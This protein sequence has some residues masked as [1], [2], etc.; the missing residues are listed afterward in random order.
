MVPGLT[1]N[2]EY[3]SGLEDGLY[4]PTATS[5][6]F[7][8][9]DAAGIQRQGNCDYG[10]AAIT[11]DEAGRLHRYLAHIGEGVDPT[12]ENE[13]QCLSNATFD[14]TGLTEGGGL[15]TDIIAPNLALI[16]ASSLT[17][18]DFDLVAAR[19]AMVVWSPRSNVFLY[20]KTLN[21]TYLLEAGITVALGT[22]WLPSGSA[23]MGREAVCGRD[24]TKKS[25]EFDLNSQTIWEMMTINAAKVA[26]FENQLGSL[27]VGK[28]A[29]IVVFSGGEGDAYSRVVYAPSE[30]LELVMRGGK[31]LVAG[32]GLE[33]LAIA[34]CEGAI[35]G[36]V[37]K[38]ICVSD[39]VNTTFAEFEA[40]LGGVYPAILPG[41][42]EME[43]T[44][45]PTR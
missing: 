17:D 34:G 28:L 31:V 33:D 6:V 8:L 1:R 26:G 15:S 19:G 4:A 22:D 38:T 3:A 40:K 21:V 36:T 13:F 18:A 20:G 16:H 12:A 11:R 32:E 2:L 44:C 43:P 27:E 24:V 9:D 7:P 25:Y 10:A 42:P 37:E 30:N 39:A 23:T 35:F 45:E 5:D 41:V 29:D 14:T